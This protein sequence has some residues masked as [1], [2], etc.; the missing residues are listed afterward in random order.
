MW[1]AF[2]NGL[3]VHGGGG[4]VTKAQGWEFVPL[5]RLERERGRG[6]VRSPLRTFSSPAPV[7]QFHE[8]PQPGLGAASEAA[9]RAQ[10]SRLDF[11][12]QHSRLKKKCEELKKRYGREKDEWMREKEQLLRE[13]ADIQGGENRRIL[14]DLR[15]VLGDVQSDLKREESKR[16]DLQL[17]YTKD[18]CAWDLERAELKCRIAQLEAQRSNARLDQAGPGAERKRLLA[19][20]HTVAMDLR[21]QLEHSEQGWLREKGELLERFDGERREWES[22]LRDMQQRI[23]ELYH[24]VKARREGAVTGQEHGTHAEALRLNLH[25]GSS[26]SSGLTGPADQRFDHVTEHDIS[27]AEETLRDSSGQKLRSFPVPMGNEPSIKSSNSFQNSNDCQNNGTCG[28]D[29]KKY[30]SAL[31][32]ALK[33]IAKVSEELCSY[34]DE[35]RKTSLHR[36]SRTQST[37]FMKEFEEAQNIKNKAFPPFQ[38]NNGDLALNS[39]WSGDLSITEEESNSINGVSMTRDLNDSFG[40]EADSGTNP[41]LRKIEAPPVPPRTTSW[42]L[43]SSA[44]PEPAD[45]HLPESKKTRETQE[46]LSERKCSSP[47]VL[48]KFGAMLQE[49]EGKTLTESGIFTHIVPADPKC[50]IGCCHS[51]WSCDI[52]RFGSSKS[53]TY[54]PVQKSLSDANIFPAD[55]EYCPDYSALENASCTNVQVQTVNKDITRKW[56]SSFSSAEKGKCTLGTPSTYIE[57][58][59]PKNNET[60]ALKTAEFNRTLFQVDASSALEEDN[61]MFAAVTASSRPSG[62]NVDCALRYTEHMDANL[63]SPDKKVS[64]LTECVPNSHV[65]N[66][67]LKGQGIKN[68]CSLWVDNANGQQDLWRPSNLASCPRPVDPSSNDGAVEK[69]LKG[70][71][72]S[73]PSY[74]T[75]KC[76]CCRQ[77]TPNSGSSQ[78][79]RDSLVELLDMLQAEHEASRLSGP[80]LPSPRLSDTPPVWSDTH[81]GMELKMNEGNDEPPSFST[82]KNFARPARP[83]NR[84]LPA[85]WAARS[86]SASSA[87]RRH[88]SFSRHPATVIV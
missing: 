24:E 39:K 22:Q 67:R 43:T 29:K 74:Q 36:R 15:S 71:E 49:N 47:S 9:T 68:V 1:N 46:S 60:L 55:T 72:Q 83:A 11:Q 12:A 81:K 77:Q 28:N 40:N 17:Q 50:N 31:N 37:S 70:F 76:G 32:A 26:G 57:M 8:E 80:R 62:L 64:A 33:E 18:R 85:R 58:S 25:S 44:A 10:T 14:L 48:K 20:T 27:E 53:S 7:T 87:Q 42:Y 51:R 79:R 16:S 6:K 2:G 65:N 19:D 23:E 52:S 13:V 30:T 84:R 75:S 63:H 54:L 61:V 4:Y 45:L 69:T 35:I 59:T 88:F 66:T 56:N 73:A 34:Q 3:P 82:K 5:S 21:R 41:S 38:S 86:P 78:T